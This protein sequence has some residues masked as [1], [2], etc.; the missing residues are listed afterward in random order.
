MKIKATRAKLRGS[1]LMPDCVRA[2]ISKHEFGPDDERCFCLGLFREGYNI[3]ECYACAA[4]VN[5]ATPPT[6]EETK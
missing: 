6:K 4:F 2:R 3:D 1:M 5:N